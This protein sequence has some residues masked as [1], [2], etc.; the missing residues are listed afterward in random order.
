M[1][2]LL[3]KIFTSN[4]IIPHNQHPLVAHY[5]P[6]HPKPNAVKVINEAFPKSSHELKD[7]EAWKHHE[8]GLNVQGRVQPMPEVLDDAG[9]PI[10]PEEVGVRGCV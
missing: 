5:N 2:K 9:E 8:I 1:H 3:H 4:Y 10:V 6:L 7:P